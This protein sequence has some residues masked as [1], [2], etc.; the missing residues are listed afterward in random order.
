[1]YDELIE[2]LKELVNRN[3]RFMKN[4]LEICKLVNE[5]AVLKR[6]LEQKEKYVEDMA[7]DLDQRSVQDPELQRRVE[8]RVQGKQEML[9]KLRQEIKDYDQEIEFFEFL[10]KEK[11]RDIVGMQSEMIESSANTGEAK[12]QVMQ[13][14]KKQVRSN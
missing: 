1:M 9:R 4:E 14:E 8:Q 7:R 6:E 12:R 2:S 13:V 11:Q 3:A 5:T 10:L